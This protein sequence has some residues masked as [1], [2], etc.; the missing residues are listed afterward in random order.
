MKTLINI[1]LIAGLAYLVQMFVPIWWLFALV[2]FLVSFAFGKNALSAFFAGFIAIFLLWT[3]QTL[4]GSFEND[5]ILVSKMSSLIQT[6][7][8]SLLF[9]ITALIGGFIAGFSSLSGYFLKTI[10]S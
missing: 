6:P 7:H 2:A 8:P 9:L 4:V 1:I 3:L 5:F 10:K